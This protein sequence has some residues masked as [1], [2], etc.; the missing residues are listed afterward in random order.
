MW[1]APN[2]PNNRISQTFNDGVLTVYAVSDASQ[3]GYKPKETLAK[4][5]MLHFEERRLGIERYY[6]GMQNQIEISRVVRVPKYEKVNSQDV[7]I[8]DG[9]QYRIDLVQHVFGIYPPCMDL[10]LAK[11]QQEYRL[12]EENDLV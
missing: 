10:T 1:K 9:V 8:I 6:N 3:P 4:K 5:V 12:E 11:I 7:A 2:R